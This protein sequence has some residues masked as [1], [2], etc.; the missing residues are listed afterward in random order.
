MTWS[1]PSR[2]CTLA[3]KR[4]KA[5]AWIVIV[6]PSNV[7]RFSTPFDTIRFSTPASPA[8]SPLAAGTDQNTMRALRR[9][10]MAAESFPQDVLELQ[11][12]L[13]D[14][15]RIPGVQA[16]PGRNTNVPLY[17]LGSSLFGAQLAALLGL[18]FGFASHFAP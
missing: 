9:D 16:T 13:G 18:P 12:F 6:C 11:A 14:E 15:S 3:R 5:S 2:R 1:P 8:K 7:T 10:P 17:I 4:A